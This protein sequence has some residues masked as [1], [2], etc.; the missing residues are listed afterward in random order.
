MATTLSTII[1]NARTVLLESSA[2]FWTDAELLV[3]ATDG[4]RDLWKAVLNLDEGHFTTIDETNVSMAASTNT[5]TGVP[6]DVFRVELIE[7]RDQTTANSVQNM[8]FEPRAVNHPDFSGS[9]SL[10]SV[11]P[12]GRTIYYSVLAAGSPVAAPTI[13]VSPKINTAVLL[14]FVYTAGLATLTSGSNNPIPGESDHAIMAW[15][16]AFARSKERADASPDPE[17]M[18]IYAADKAHILG[19]LEPRQTQEPEVVEAMFESY[20]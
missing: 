16:I 10:G 7:V 2:N 12:S 13:L 14:R 15:I 8:T 6:S 5:L 1:T 18:A 11:D 17:W 9:R 20:T 3:Y 4:V 19:A